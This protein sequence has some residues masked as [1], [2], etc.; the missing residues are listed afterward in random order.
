MPVCLSFP[1]DVCQGVF[2]E[3]D[4][5]I[6]LNFPMA[7]ETLMKLRMTARF[8]GKTFLLQKFGKWVK[9]SF[10]LFKEKIRQNFH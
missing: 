4:H 9:N 10:F 5:E 2:L 1:S 6:S 7:L 3:F 8:F